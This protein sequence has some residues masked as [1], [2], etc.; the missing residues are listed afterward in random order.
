M[1]GNTKC[2]IW[3]G[4]GVRVDPSSLAISPFDR[5]PTTSYSTLIETILHYFRVTA[6]YLSKVAY[7]NLTHL[8]L[9]ILW[10]WSHSNFAETFG[11]WKL[12]SLGYCMALFACPFDT[13][14]A[15]DGWTD[16]QMG[17]RTHNVG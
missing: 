8:H 12:E 4:S 5:A 11:I 16:G 6:S 17:G 3:G 13:I 9:C 15:Y 2:T 7:F 14:P 1:K 10:V